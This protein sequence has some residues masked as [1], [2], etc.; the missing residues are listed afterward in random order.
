MATILHII[1]GLGTGGAERSLLSLVSGGLAEQHQC[2]VVSLTDEVAFGPKIAALGVPVHCL[3]MSRGRPTPAALMRLRQFVRTIR[4]E[5]IQGWMYHGNMAAYLARLMA[6]GRPALAWNIRQSL[7]DISKEKPGTRAVIRA[8]RL[9]S[10]QP[11]LILYNSRVARAQHEAFGYH[12]TKGAVI[13]NGFDTSLWRPDADAREKLREALRLGPND[14]LVGFVARYHPMK[15]IPNFLQAMAALMA[16]DP[17]LH[18]CM[19]GQDAGPENPTLARYFAELPAD[20]LHVLGR[21]DDIAA[22]MPGFDL[23]CLSSSYGEGFPNVLG[24]AMASAVPCVATD[25]GDCRHVIGDTGQIVAASDSIALRRALADMLL[26]PDDARI[27]LGAKARARIIDHFSLAA[28]VDQYTT[29]YDS[30]LKG[31]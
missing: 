18:C 22:L 15:D 2:E 9:V 25:V 6:I 26:M 3:G 13:A 17:Y 4:P 20:R 12:A 10:W 16:A 7:Y 27:S 29:L 28:T 5:F 8:S 31:R 30:I 1:T 19:V 14:K 11:D 23:C 21:R 24:E